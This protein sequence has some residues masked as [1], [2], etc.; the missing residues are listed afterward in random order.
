MWSN[1]FSSEFLQLRV[2]YTEGGAW[3]TIASTSDKHSSNSQAWKTL[4]ATGLNSVV[5]GVQVLARTYSASSS[6]DNLNPVAIDDISVSYTSVCDCATLS[7]TITLAPS[8]VPS[9][10]S[11][12]PNI[13]INNDND[14]EDNLLTNGMLVY[15]GIAAV[16]FIAVMACFCWCDNWRTGR[17]ER[18][19]AR[20]S[21]EQREREANVNNRF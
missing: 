16:I 1:C 14:D 19:A 10:S 20:Y 3:N 6:C 9:T 15:I 13:T 7:P 11:P 17:R 18:K 8:G 4:S 12:T 5:Y 21:A 2:Q